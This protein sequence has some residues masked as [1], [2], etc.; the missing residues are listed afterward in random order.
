MEDKWIMFAAIYGVMGL[1]MLFVGKKFCKP[2]FFLMGLILVAL[3]F[4]IQDALLL[5][6]AG[7]AALALP[8]GEISSI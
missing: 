8:F 7:L 5:S 3:P 4:F 2:L 6:L 1:G